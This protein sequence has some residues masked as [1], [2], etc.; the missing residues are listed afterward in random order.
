MTLLALWTAFDA[1]AR[2]LV[3]LTTSFAAGK[4]A[5]LSASSFTLYDECLLEGLLSRIWQ[6]WSLF[7][8][9]CLI[10]SCIGTTDGT[11]NIVSG[12]TQAV[13]EHHVSSA[14]MQAKRNRTPLWGGTNATLRF[15][16]TWGDVDNLVALIRALNPANNAQLLAAFSSGYAPAKAIQRIRNASA[17]HH[18]Q[19]LADVA[20][21]GASY[22]AYP[23]T[24]PTHA[25]LWVEPSASDFLLVYA[26]EELSTT[27]RLAIG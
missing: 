1:S 9:Q 2:S 18:A 26:I 27:A 17:H 23:I 16:P 24:H 4:P 25:L 5:M 21:L 10:E 11:G 14:A 22:L 15:E 7:C 19:N 6:E 12:L 3:S 8:R 20:A 13:S